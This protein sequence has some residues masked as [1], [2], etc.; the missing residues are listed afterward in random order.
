MTGLGGVKAQRE[1]GGR[2][3]EVRGVKSRTRNSLSGPRRERIK[4][5]LFVLQYYT[6]YYI[7][8]V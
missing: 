2:K 7:T 1:D 3:G 5:N 8:L 4:Q 6:M